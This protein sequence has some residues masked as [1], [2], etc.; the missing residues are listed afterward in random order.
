[1]CVSIGG[2]LSL[3]YSIYRR[4]TSY[5]QYS[6]RYIHCFAYLDYRDD[7]DGDSYDH[8]DIDLGGNS[9][10][11]VVIIVPVHLLYREGGVILFLFSSECEMHRALREQD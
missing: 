10:L 7:G 2:N 4:L 11:V 5:I 9:L 6:A 3:H 8:S 1:M